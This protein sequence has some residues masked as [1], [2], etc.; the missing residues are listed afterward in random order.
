MLEKNREK[1]L[2]E[3]LFHHAHIGAHGISARIGHDI[4]YAVHVLYSG[5]LG[6][7]FDVDDLVVARG[8]EILEGGFLMV[9]RVP[10]ERLRGV[11]QYPR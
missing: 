6:D 10:V 4:E 1:M 2:S 9:A 5:S 7:L 8:V 3:G 11:V